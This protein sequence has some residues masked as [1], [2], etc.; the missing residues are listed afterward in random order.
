MIDLLPQADPHVL[1][2]AMRRTITA[3]K[4]AGVNIAHSTRAKILTR[5]CVATTHPQFYLFLSFFLLFSFFLS[6]TST[7]TYSRLSRPIFTAA[8][9]TVDPALLVFSASTLMP[10]S[11]PRSLALVRFVE[12]RSTS[13]GVPSLIPG[14]AYDLLLA[15]NAV[16][17]SCSTL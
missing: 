11:V 1:R 2:E 8:R 7:T 14:P 12:C 5:C 10:M 6:L 17:M 13:I 15:Y 16:A 4:A 9:V 3:G